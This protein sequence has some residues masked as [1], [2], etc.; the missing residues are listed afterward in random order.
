MN[1]IWIYKI[2]YHQIELLNAKSFG[3]LTFQS[4]FSKIKLIKYDFK[5]HNVKFTE[6]YSKIFL[7]NE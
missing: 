7:R 3:I 6:F 5:L 4:L 1:Y 2:F